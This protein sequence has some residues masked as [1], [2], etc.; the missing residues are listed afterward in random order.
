MRELQILA[1]P[2]HLELLD[3]LIVE[4]APLGLV[5]W[6]RHSALVAH[7]LET[8]GERA[9][10]LP[11]VPLA[12][13][14]HD[15]P[16]PDV[17]VVSGRPREGP[18]RPPL[19]DEILA[20]VE[21]AGTSFAADTNLKHKLYA[22]FA[23]PDYLVVDLEHDLVAHIP[24]ATGTTIPSPRPARTAKRC[25]SAGCPASSSAATRF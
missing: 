25:V 1:E 16:R 15:E 3:G 9:A 7:L 18:R 13:G 4:K 19:P 12:L 5:Q 11:H 21:L 22:R 24:A 23:I 10:V 8:L 6:H 14:E 17:A 2:E 20:L